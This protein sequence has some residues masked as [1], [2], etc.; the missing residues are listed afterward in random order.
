MHLG[1]RCWADSAQRGLG[2]LREAESGRVP[3]LWVQTGAVHGR[4]ASWNLLVRDCRDEGGDGTSAPAG[5]VKVQGCPE[6]RRL[7][8]I[9]EASARP[10]CC[11]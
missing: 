1:R 3:G 2:L 4:I 8:G 10:G 7:A 5:D 6:W 11:R 9:W